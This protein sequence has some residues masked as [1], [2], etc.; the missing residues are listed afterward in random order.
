MLPALALAGIL[1]L[2]V[3]VGLATRGR[4]WLRLDRGAGRAER[5]QVEA[6]LANAEALAR[7]AE[8]EL[9]RHYGGRTAA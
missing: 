1:L 4:R 5:D 2:A 9:V 7:A 3:I 6:C 8:E